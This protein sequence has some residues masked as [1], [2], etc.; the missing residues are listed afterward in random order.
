M[1][2][3]AI[4]AVGPLE[5]PVSD[6]LGDPG[7][8]VPRRRFGHH[9]QYARPNRIEG[10]DILIELRRLDLQVGSIGDRRS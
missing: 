8:G 9:G 10:P 1:G 4:D 3:A 5:G 2:P 6:T 7:E